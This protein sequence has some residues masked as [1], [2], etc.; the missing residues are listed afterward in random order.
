MTGDSASWAP[1]QSRKC[2]FLFWEFS[3]SPPCTCH[4]IKPWQRH[5][6]WEFHLTGK[7]YRILLNYNPSVQTANFHFYTLVACSAFRFNSK[8]CLTRNQLTVDIF[9][10][11][12]NGGWW[13]FFLWIMNL[14]FA[15]LSWSGYVMLIKIS[16]LK[17][18]SSNSDSP[19]WFG[20]LNSFPAVRSD[21]SC[22]GIKKVCKYIYSQINLDPV[23]V[24]SGAVLLGFSSSATN[25]N[26]AEV[27]ESE[28]LAF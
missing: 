25:S 22:T 13:L 14:D 27:G 11:I 24:P 21:R 12:N 23:A 1:W 18:E 3:P 8:N 10:S 16:T 6:N 9:T 2:S 4:C 26:R 28:L 15:N 17:T 20:V 5:A 7:C 19:G